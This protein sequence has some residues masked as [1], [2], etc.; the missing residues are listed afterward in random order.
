MDG[1]FL[2]YCAD[3][4]INIINRPLTKGIRSGLF[5]ETLTHFHYKQPTVYIV[6][7]HF[8]L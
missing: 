8:G 6:L 1:A 4:V 3:I 5:S 2:I 7:S